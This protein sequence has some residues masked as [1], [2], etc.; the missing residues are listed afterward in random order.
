MRALIYETIRNIFHSLS[1]YIHDEHLTHTYIR[2]NNSLVAQIQ[3]G[4]D[5][6]EDHDKDE[7]PK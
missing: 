1:S 7:G 5:H 2:F 4:A 6:D 3:Y